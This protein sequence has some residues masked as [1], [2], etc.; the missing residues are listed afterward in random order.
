MKV[1]NTEGGGD[2]TVPLWSAS[3]RAGQR[4]V[5]VN[6]H[7]HVFTG[8]PFKRVFFR[9][10]GG[11]LGPALEGVLSPLPPEPLRLSV[12]APIVECYKDFELLLIPPA[13]V[14]QIDGAIVLRT[15]GDDGLAESPPQE[16]A[17][18]QYSGVP[19][20]TLRLAMPGLA[21]PGWYQLNF[22][23]APGNYPPLRFAAI[24]L[25]N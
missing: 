24:R 2:G 7:A 23:G 16:F 9:L 25:P 13:P 18:I 22:V 6:E 11:N 10:L 3:P 14:G 8:N 21:N 15:L 17:R 5:V 4:E 1:T 12:P 20:S 19:V